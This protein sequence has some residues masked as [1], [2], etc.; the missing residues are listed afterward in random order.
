MLAAPLILFAVLDAFLRSTVRVRSGLILL[1]ISAVNA[2]LAVA[3]GLI[4]ANTLRP[5]RFLSIPAGLSPSPGAVS[6]AHHDRFLDDLL[7]LLPTNL[8]DPFRTNAIAPIV[9]LAVLAGAALR[10]YKHERITAGSR[11]YLAIE[12]LVALNL[13]RRAA[14]IWASDRRLQAA[15]ASP[16][17]ELRQ[18]AIQEFL[19]TAVEK[20]NLFQIA[21]RNPLINVF[22]LDPDGNALAD[23]MR[24][25]P[26]LGKNYRVRD[27][28]RT[29]LEHEGPADRAYVA[30]SFLSTKDAHYKI[31]IST[32]IWDGGGKLLGILVA[33]FPIGPRLIDVDMG[34]ER[35]DA[36]IL[37]PMDRS[38]PTRGV[39]DPGRPWEYISALDRRY[40]EDGNDRPFTLDPS[41]LPDFQD[42]PG[43]DRA[44]AGPRGGQLVDYHRVGETPL[45]AVVR[46]KCPWPLSWLP[47]LR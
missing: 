1:G 15:F 6:G 7:G 41:R 28:Y 18:R 10:R 21:G 45:I 44:T 24:R 12:S 46:R 29:L 43:L 3:I 40:A 9:V 4:L 31:A 13:I 32:R 42:D 39:V 30:R 36:A 34:R 25:S 37:C 33:N 20:E 8:V 19:E 5:G 38:D 27:Y 26:Y 2:A 11:D 14:Q 35:V 22:V 17:A 47:H 23:T 16:P